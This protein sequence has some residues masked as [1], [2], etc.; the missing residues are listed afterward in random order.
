MHSVLRNLQ[1]RQVGRASSHLTLRALQFLQPVLDFL[2]GRFEWYGFSSSVL[3]ADVCASGE[4]EAEDSG[5]MEGGS[6]Q[7]RGFL[8]RGQCKMTGP[9]MCGITS[10]SCTA[11]I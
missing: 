4:D 10:P 5:M 7:P 2:W 11:Y 8:S 1:D 9:G 6:T 3:D